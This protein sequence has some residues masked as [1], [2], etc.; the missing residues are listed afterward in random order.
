MALLN[1]LL[2]EAA[3]RSMELAQQAGG[4][5]QAVDA[6]SALVERGFEERESAQNGTS[7]SSGPCGTSDGAGY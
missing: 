7:S 2:E 1:E 3:A 4:A 5:A 6:L